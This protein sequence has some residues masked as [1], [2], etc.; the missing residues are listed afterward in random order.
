MDI[1]SRIT[2]HLLAER[3]LRLRSVEEAL[4]RERKKSQSWRYLTA[5]SWAIAGSAILP[6]F[7]RGE[8]VAQGPVETGS[9]RFDSGLAEP[10]PGPDAYLFDGDTPLDS[11]GEMGELSNGLP[12]HMKEPISEPLASLPNPGQFLLPGV[13]P[14]VPPYALPSPFLPPE[15]QISEVPVVPP[16][17]IADG[18]ATPLPVPLQLPPLGNSSDLT[19][20]EL[21]GAPPPFLP[22][23]PNKASPN[24][25]VV[26]RSSQSI[27]AQ[28]IMPL[29]RPEG[30]DVEGG[31]PLPNVQLPQQ[32]LIASG[33]QLGPSNIPLGSSQSFPVFENPKNIA[34]SELLPIPVYLEAA[35]PMDVVATAPELLSVPE[36]AEAESLMVPGEIEIAPPMDAVATA[37]ELSSV[38]EMAEAES[39]IGTSNHTRVLLSQGMINF[40]E[41]A[42]SQTDFH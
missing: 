23:F 39:L 12:S 24:E 16:V 30:V 3:N 10:L 1:S 2:P 25:G 27:A 32:V 21:P 35:P 41:L 9:P 7:F 33:E 31:D 14:T 36:M 42:E 13:L 40:P 4:T 29:P 37:P 18:R 26:P 34:S 19:I 6:A 15:A 5:A 17:T 22:Q 8:Q 28:E 38:P 11:L 20:S